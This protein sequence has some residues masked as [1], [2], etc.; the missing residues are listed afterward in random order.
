[1]SESKRFSWRNLFIGVAVL[2][3]VVVVFLVQA[4]AG[5]NAR[6]IEYAEPPEFVELH[7][8]KIEHP[9]P[10]P[11]PTEQEREND[12]S[13]EVAGDSNITSEFENEKALVHK[14]ILEGESPDVLVRLLT[15]PEQAQRVKAALALA[16]FNVEMAFDSP[17]DSWKKK[18]QFWKSVD[19][20]VPDIRNALFEALIVSAQ[21]GTQN[22]IPYTIAWM[23]GQDHETVELLGWAANHHR[24]DSVR[25][26][27]TFFV[28]TLEPN[29]EQAK[30][31]LR[32]GANDP[33]F[34]VRKEVFVERIE[35][36]FPFLNF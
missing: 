10:S 5:L 27:A 24:N 19:E 2:S 28:F 36:V 7:T 11:S 30:Q 1:V 32:T 15:H 8:N 26:S 6:P 34:F 31:L 12:S 14:V 33:S 18:D 25:S 9:E 22:Y 21:E 29:S 4:L 20:H 16:E 13:E 35:R 3:F 17:E 23:P